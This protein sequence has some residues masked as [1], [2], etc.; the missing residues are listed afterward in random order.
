MRL[1]A[2]YRV[3]TDR[4]GRSGLG[5]EAQQ[6][7]VLAYAAAGSHDLLNAYTEVESGRN[8]HRPQLLE[9]IQYARAVLRSRRMKFGGSLGRIPPEAAQRGRLKGGEK[10]AAKARFYTEQL[11]LNQA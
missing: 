8:D 4:Q 3:S 5:P 1:V 7:C 9:A 10:V 2:Y 6:R 11:G